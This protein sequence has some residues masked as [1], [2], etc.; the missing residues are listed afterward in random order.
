MTSNPVPFIISYKP[1]DEIIHC[2]VQLLIV[3]QEKAGSIVVSKVSHSVD[4]SEK[5]SKTSFQ[6]KMLSVHPFQRWPAIAN[7][8][9]T[10]AVNI[11][12]IEMQEN[13]ILVVLQLFL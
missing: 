13:M 7:N 12:G 11:P 9:L 4:G 8:L 5:S 6:L 3:Q 1:V 10:S 2:L